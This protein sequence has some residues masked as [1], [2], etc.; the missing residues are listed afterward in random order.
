MGCAGYSPYTTSAAQDDVLDRI[1]QRAGPE[2]VAVFDLDGCLYDNRWR[3]LQIINEYAG[4]HDVPDLH[5]VR[6]HHFRD[7]SLSRT[8]RNAGIDPGRV[9]A[10]AEEL[11]QFWWDRFFSGEYV[12]FDHAMP[13]AVRLV[14]GVR[15]RGAHIVYLTGRDVTMHEGTVRALARDGF[16]APDDGP[17][18]LLTK[19]AIDMADE[20]WKAE[21][22]ERI[23]AL[24]R[25]TVFLD[26]EPVNVNLFAARHPDA[27]VVFVSTDHSFRPDAPR[28]E[29]PVVRGFLRTTDPVVAERAQFP[30]G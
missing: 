29:I 11:R 14:Q 28:P 10:F 17:A 2:T 9:E 13:G 21:A 4:Q 7:W 8:A 30:S 15:A 20:D 24:G 23:A 3:Q 6:V 16:P 5:G 12:G 22:L 27:L 18:A 19:P 25:P 26:N 1:L